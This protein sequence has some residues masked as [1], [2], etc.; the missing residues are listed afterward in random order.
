[1][2]AFS[3]IK[4]AIHY[5]FLFE[6]LQEF[7][8]IR[9]DRHSVSFD[10]GPLQG[11]VL[12]VNKMK[13]EFDLLLAYL[14]DIYHKQPGQLS[15]TLE[16]THFDPGLLMER[17]GCRLQWWLLSCLKFCLLLGRVANQLF[18]GGPE[19]FGGEGFY[20]LGVNRFSGFGVDQLK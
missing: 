19:K 16:H 18:F 13:D 15:L 12:F 4:P 14:Q 17:Q 3:Q 10:W 11:V 5:Y 8:S 6:G 2:I 20:F 1:M 9:V 7:W